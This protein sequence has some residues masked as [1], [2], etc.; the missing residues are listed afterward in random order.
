MTKNKAIIDY[1]E[2]MR[3][4]G[5]NDQQIKEKLQAAGWDEQIINNHFQED[6]IP[7]PDDIPRPTPQTEEPLKSLHPS[8]VWLL[9]TRHFGAVPGLL[10]VAYWLFGNTIE[11]G[12][13]TDFTMYMTYLLLIIAIGGI[14]AFIIAKLEYHFYHYQIKSE[15]FYKERGIIAKKYVTIPYDRIQNIDIHQNVIAR[16]LGLYSIK[17][18]TAG[19]SGVSVA[20]GI[21]PGVNKEEAE[22]L[23]SELLKRARA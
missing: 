2:N 22:R 8:A 20:E 17:I 14:I 11:I 23:K 4:R 21:L 18:Q 15:G 19:N 6:D 3:K 5:I 16:L 9:A 7:K 10:L 13:I 1:I 12:E